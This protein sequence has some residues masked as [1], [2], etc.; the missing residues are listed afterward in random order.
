MK[1][2]IVVLAIGAAAVAHCTSNT[3]PDAGVDGAAIDA[4]LACGPVD[5]SSFKPDL[6]TAPHAPHLGKCTSQQIDDYA[7]CQ[8]AKNTDL[9]G[10]FKAGQPAADCGACI[11]TQQGAPEW[12]V[13]VFSGSTALFNIEGCVDD[14]LGQVSSEVHTPDAGAGSCGDELHASYGCQETACSACTNGDFTICDSQVLFAGDD[15]SA[16]G[17]CKVWDDA[18]NDPSGP[19]APL[20]SPTPPADVASCFPDA[21]LASDT[22]KQE[23][24]W[25]TRI[26][27]YMCGS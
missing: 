9:C 26:V 15:A 22:T 2:A 18:V 16:P 4:S 3:T 12:G 17:E 10:Q 27:T 7:Q 6:M 19:C 13:I 20:F 23:V 8:G 11:E 14:A 1:R 5:V 24:D 21:S 25:L